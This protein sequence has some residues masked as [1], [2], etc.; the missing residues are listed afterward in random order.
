[1]VG[2]ELYDVNIIGEI[3]DEPLE[4]EF[5]RRE[6]AGRIR[7]MSWV[8]LFAGV[9]FAAAAFAGLHVSEHDGGSWL[10]L[11]GRLSVLLV[12]IVFF[13]GVRFNF[14]YS[15]STLLFTL[16]EMAA[17]YNVLAMINES[18]GFTLVT[19]SLSAA[20]CITVM[21]TL[22]G[23]WAYSMAAAVTLSAAMVY[24]STFYIRDIDGAVLPVWAVSMAVILVSASCL[25]FLYNRSRRHHFIWEHDQLRRAMTDALTGIG[26]RK[27]FDADMTEAILLSQRNVPFCVIILDLNDFSELVQKYGAGAGDSALV[28]FS[29]LIIQN[30]RGYEN[31]SRYDTSTF[32][33]ITPHT[34]M[35]D[36]TGLAQRLCRTTTMT[37]FNLPVRL[38][39]G[40]GLAAS[41]ADDTAET[42]MDRAMR[43]TAQAKRLGKNMVVTE[44]EMDE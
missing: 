5:R 15:L 42:I 21:L 6:L 18:K 4:S 33:L 1:M 23:R 19:L 2:L 39:C 32:C 34:G 17:A 37:E 9:G 3:S 22:P 7:V 26:N 41:H 43:C 14:S 20:A 12:S 35:E 44:L 13:I 11:T 30:I 28:A 29:K 16:A 27:K 38:T 10:D 40:V 31:F 25:S 24:I 36:A 8:M